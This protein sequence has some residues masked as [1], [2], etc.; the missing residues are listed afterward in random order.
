MAR[1]RQNVNEDADPVEAAPETEA[2]SDG[3]DTA[4]LEE[5]AGGDAS[6]EAKPAEVVEEAP[7]EAIAEINRCM[8]VTRRPMQV[9]DERCQA[10]TVIGFISTTPGT[11]TPE[12]VAHCIARGMVQVIPVGE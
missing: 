6:A 4:A 9:G 12:F 1:K 2:G 11:H 10:G 7:I 8:V 3:Q 5:V